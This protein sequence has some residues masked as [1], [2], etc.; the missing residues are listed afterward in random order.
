MSGTKYN[1]EMS[2][3]ECPTDLE[4]EHESP[5]PAGRRRRLGPIGVW[6][7]L[8]T[9]GNLVSGFAA[10]HYAAKPIGPDLAFGPWGWSSLTVA[11]SLVLLG[12]VLD[13]FDGAVARLTNSVT[14]LG[15]QLDSFADIVTF[16]VAPAFIMLNLLSQYLGTGETIVSP[17]AGNTLGKFCWAIAAI[18]VCCA[19]L[20]LARFNVETASGR[21][22]DHMN[23]RGL[24]T[25]GAAGAVVG[26]VILHEHLEHIRQGSEHSILSAVAAGIVLLVPV[27]TLISAIMMVSAVPYS[28]M[29]NRYL[30]G[31]RSFGYLVRVV[32]VLSLAVWWLQ[33]TLAIVFVL[34]V[35]SGPWRMF[36]RK[37]DSAS[38]VEVE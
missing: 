25:P 16:G 21:L 13:A 33:E 31:S 34:Y 36:F 17:D 30:R 3:T 11:A 23:F 20:R 29:A 5:A 9:L 2:V 38:G 19:A 27:I 1:A 18:Y 32:A 28:H 10:I 8:L 12:T 22:G 35:L 15:G 26:L 4:P 24:P 14:E 7:T 6:P 37:D